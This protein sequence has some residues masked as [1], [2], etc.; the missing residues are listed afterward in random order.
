[1]LPHVAF[2]DSFSNPSRSLSEMLGFVL[3][4][5]MVMKYKSSYMNPNTESFASLLEDARSNDAYFEERAILEFTEQVVAKMHERKISKKELAERMNVSPAF[6][7]KFLSGDN[8]FT[9][10]LVV[11]VAR[12]L[13]MEFH[14]MLSS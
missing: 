3:L 12:A 10:C 5:I 7:T 6:V 4:Q 11:K 9:F 13:D 1:M 8:N 14:P 2:D